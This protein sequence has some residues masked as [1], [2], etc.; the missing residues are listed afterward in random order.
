MAAILGGE[1]NFLKIA[2][3]KSTLLRYPM[4]RN[5][6]ISHGKGDRSKLVFFHF[7]RKFKMAAIF[8]ERKIFLKIATKYTKVAK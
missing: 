3:S 8:G 6:S 5:R 7:C 2:K 4:G 1:E